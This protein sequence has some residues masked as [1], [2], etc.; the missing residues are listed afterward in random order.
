MIS[1]ICSYVSFF[2]RGEY[3][4]RVVYKD[5][6]ELANV[7]R[8][9]DEVRN[10]WNKKYAV[11]QGIA[12]GCSS[13]GF[14]CVLIAVPALGVVEA[15]AV[16]IAAITGTALFLFATVAMIRAIQAKYNVDHLNLLEK[17]FAPILSLLD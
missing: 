5:K 1:E 12:M 16:S 17:N 7:L 3:A 13:A 11:F 9:V 14:L 15:E 2:I 4:H 8:R 10:E 6:S